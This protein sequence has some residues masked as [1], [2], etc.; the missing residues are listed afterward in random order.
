M[1]DKE[2]LAALL[3]ELLTSQRSPEEV[4]A[5]C[6]ELLPQVRRRWRQMRRVRA[7]LDLLFPPSN[8]GAARLF[9]RHPTSRL[10]R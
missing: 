8:V 3:D 4:C 5:S 1:N 6:P 10:S 7:Q 9:H 2:R